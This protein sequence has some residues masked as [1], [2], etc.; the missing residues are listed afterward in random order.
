MSTHVS[1][2]FAYLIK[3]Q[4]VI[5]P[6]NSYS[7][8][9]DLLY[10]RNTFT[11]SIGYNFT[12][13]A[14]S[15]PK[16]HLSR[17]TSLV[18]FSAD[19]IFPDTRQWEDTQRILQGMPRLQSCHFVLQ[20]SRLDSSSYTEYRASRFVDMLKELPKKD[21][22]VV[23]FLVNLDTPYNDYGLSKRCVLKDEPVC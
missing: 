14:R 20:L 13:F 18:L 1:V 21:A 7:E 6:R 3:D 16:Q 9:I 15:V 22:F 23:D 8:A 19:E 11:T 10:S 5:W 4:S 12:N 17:I 2:P